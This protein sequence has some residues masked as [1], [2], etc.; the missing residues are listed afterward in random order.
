MDHQDVVQRARTA[1]QSGKTKDVAFRRRQL[2]AL[3]K[4][5][6]ENR[7]EIAAVLAADLRR[8]RQ[9][10]MALEVDVLIN[11]MTNT[12]NNLDEW[13]GV[14]KPD[15]SI[16]NA[17]DDVLIY[18]EPFGVALVM[19]AWNYPIMLSM[20]PFGAAIAAGNAVILK[21]SEISPKSAKFMAE[22]VAKYLDN[23]SSTNKKTACVNNF[24]CYRNATKSYAEAFPRQQNC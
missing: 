14:E 23:V 18:K 15:K 9:E 20:L 21:P 22:K 5:Y 6:E 2:E 11:D 13:A 1:F 3:L 10:T 12:L 24:L 4:L 16:V 17:L 8:P 7:D 19:G